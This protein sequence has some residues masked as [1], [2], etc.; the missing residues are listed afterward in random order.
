MSATTPTTR[1]LVL[2]IDEINDDGSPSPQAKQA[3]LR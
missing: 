3:P 1:S 2:G